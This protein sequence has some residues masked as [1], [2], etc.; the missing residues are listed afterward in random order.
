MT[1]ILERLE[2]GD[3]GTFGRLTAGSFRAFTGELPWRDNRTSVSCVPVG[4]YRVVWAYS[5]SFKRFTYRLLNVPARSGVLKHAATFMG[6]K[7]LG[8]RTHLQGCIALAEKIG[9]MDG[10]KCLLVSMPAV[11]RFEAFMAQQPFEL[12]IRNA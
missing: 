1:V 2:S 4:T 8:F 3:Q 10:Q 5:P 11:R 6:D 12:E 7:A 9:W